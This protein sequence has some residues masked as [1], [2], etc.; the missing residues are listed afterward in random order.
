MLLEKQHNF[1][2]DNACTQRQITMC[3]RNGLMILLSSM[4][5]NLKGESFCE[6]RP[7]GF[8]T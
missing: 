5:G 3:A 8:K 4:F 2:Q 7:S 1:N 6:V